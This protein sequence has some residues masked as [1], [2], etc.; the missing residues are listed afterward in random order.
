LGQRSSSSSAQGAQ[1]V[2]SKLQMKAPGVRRQVL[3]AA[4]ASGLHRQHQAA[5][6]TARRCRRPPLDLAGVV[7]FG[8]DPDQRLGAR[9]AD[10]QPAAPVQSS[11]SASAMRP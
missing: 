3:A 2:H 7:A 5:A 4:L 9:L 11:R 10:H 1:K 8:H 6:F